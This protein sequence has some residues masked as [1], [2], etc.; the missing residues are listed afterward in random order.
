MAIPFTSAGTT[1]YI[2]AGVPATINQAGFDAL[3]YTKISEVTDVGSIGPSVAIV[4]HVPVDTGI[5]LKLKTIKDNGSVALKGARQT[6]D[7]GQTLLV[8]AVGVYAPY[9]LKLVLQNG[10]IIYS[11]VLVSS[12]KTNVGTAGVVTTFDSELAVSGEIVVV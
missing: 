4:E 6:S 1:V 2:S 3:T 8:N 7:A 11:Q 9:A 12:Y 5:K 10:T